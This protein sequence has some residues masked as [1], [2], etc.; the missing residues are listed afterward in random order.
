M[1][2]RAGATGVAMR[3]ATAP[4]TA[5]AGAGDRPRPGRPRRR[6]SRGRRRRRRRAEQARRFARR[7]A[8]DDYATLVGLRDQAALTTDAPFVERLVHFWANHFAVS[9]DKLTWSGW[10]ARSSSRRSGRMCSAVSPTCSTRSS[11]IRRC[12]CISIRRQSVGPDS[13]LGA[14]RA[15]RRADG[16]PQGRAERESRARDPRTAHAGGAHRLYPG[17]RHRIRARDDRLDRRRARARAAAGCAGG[18]R[19]ISASPPAS[20]NPARGRSWARRYPRRGE[21]QAQAVLD[22]LAVASR[23]R[24]ASRDQ[25]R[26]PFR[27][28]H[29]AARDGRPARAPRS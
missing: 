16:N 1:R 8:R 11:A 2:R 27:G 29:A 22:D 24:D 17:R 25:A 15:A 13:P 23:D 4:M 26:P 18:S 9:A 6:R 21:A 12:C 19:A 3:A 28:R 7:Q 5:M 20:T 14:G 10:R